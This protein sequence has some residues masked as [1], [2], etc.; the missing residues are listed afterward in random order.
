VHNE[1]ITI[2]GHQLHKIKGLRLSQASSS[3]GFGLQVHIFFPHFKINHSPHSFQHSNHLSD[4]SIASFIDTVLR[5]ALVRHAPSSVLGHHPLSARHAFGKASVGRETMQGGRANQGTEEY[6]PGT[7][8][9]P[10][11]VRYDVPWAAVGRVWKAMEALCNRDEEG[12]F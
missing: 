9:G 4:Q 8:T 5:P 7:R 11:D 3:V 10:I 12:L 2:N 1:R 6:G